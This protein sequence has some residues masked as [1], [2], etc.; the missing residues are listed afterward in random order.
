M[1]SP[2]MDLITQISSHLVGEAWSL[3][4]GPLAP[5]LLNFNAVGAT[6]SFLTGSRGSLAFVR[7]DRL[8]H[9]LAELCTTSTRSKRSCE[10][11]S[12]LEKIDYPL[13]LGLKVECS[14]NRPPH[15]RT[16]LSSSPRQQSGQGD[17]PQAKGRFLGSTPGIGV[18][19]NCVGFMISIQM[20]SSRLRSWKQPSHRLPKWRRKLGIVR[21]F[22]YLGQLPTACGFGK[23]FPRDAESLLAGERAPTR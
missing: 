3:Q 20:A 23:R 10:R 5:C 7:I 6:G 9:L 12:R 1:A 11:S 13:H 22:A 21:L 4:L 16:Q 17:G 8:G 14:K 2:C 15:S 19:Q 18:R